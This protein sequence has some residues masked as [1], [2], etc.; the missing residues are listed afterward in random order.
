MPS[1]VFYSA[2]EFS[3]YIDK[4]YSSIP[5]KKC[6]SCGKM[7][8][9]HG[10]SSL[11]NRTCYYDLCDLIAAYE[12]EEAAEPDPRIVE[13]FTK[14]SETEHGFPPVERLKKYMAKKSD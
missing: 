8:N 4:V 1:K 2:T 10:W 3:A 13:Y 11:C 9:Y 7:A 12:K 5:Q 6:I 14:H